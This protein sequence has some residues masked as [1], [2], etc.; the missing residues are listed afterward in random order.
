MN[1]K[2]DL[3][4]ELP[5]ETFEKLFYEKWI[6]KEEGSFGYSEFRECPFRSKA[7]T[8]MPVID[9]EQMKKLYDSVYRE[10][11]TAAEGEDENE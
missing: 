8:G 9:G 6:E 10:I 4:I 2:K 5:A 3:S 7:F 11:F 1:N